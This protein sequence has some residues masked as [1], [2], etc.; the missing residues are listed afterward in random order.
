MLEFKYV[1]SLTAK[2]RQIGAEQKLQY[3]TTL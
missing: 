2:R 1:D 3:I